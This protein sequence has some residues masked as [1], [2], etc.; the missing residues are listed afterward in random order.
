MM[1][2]YFSAGSCSASCHIAIEETGM[3]YQ[4]MKVDFDKP[5]ATLAEMERLNPLGAAPVMVSSDGRTLTQNIAILEHIADSNP[6]SKLLAAPGT[7]E[8]LETM[9]WT[10]FVASDLHKAFLPLFMGKSMASTEAA[11]GEI[12]EFAK[13]DIAKLLTYV[14]GKLANRDYL[15]GKIFTIADSY[16]F[17]VVGWCKWVGVTT[18]PYSNLNAFMT[19]TY[20]RPAVQKALKMQGLLN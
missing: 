15:M 20:Q 7:W 3:S 1:K 2:L 9:S 17:V 12:A 11:Q 6:A 16:L 14:D 8:R 10:S 4:P 13:K 5:D 19:R 18:E